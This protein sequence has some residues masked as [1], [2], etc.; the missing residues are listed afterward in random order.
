MDTAF[1]D[2]FDTATLD[3]RWCLTCPGGGTAGASGSA[4]R[5]AIPASRAS[6]YANAQIDDYDHQPR[7]AYRWR[8]PLRLTVRARASAPQHP[9]SPSV[10]ATSVTGANPTSTLRGTAGFG[11]WNYPF[12]PTG[13]VLAPP[14]AIWFFYASPPSNMALV[15]SVPGWGWKAQV[16]HARR[17]GAL[18][19][20]PPA[21]VTVAWARLTGHVAPAAAWVRRLSG[22]VEAHLV[23]DLADW[24]EYALE[25]RPEVARFLVDGAEVLTAPEPPRGPL[26]FVAWID[27]HCAVATPRGTLRFGALDTPAQWLELDSVRVIRG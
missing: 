26:G 7:R 10:T 14:E 4:L 1:E 5:L 9:P 13:A 17:W 11:F 3:A 8:P 22:A 23:P 16:V 24:H 20:L 25:W 21:L 27:N 12:A 19:A 2:D 6:V 15:P 18:A